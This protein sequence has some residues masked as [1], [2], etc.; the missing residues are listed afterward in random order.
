MG[1]YL[2]TIYSSIP[3]VR[4]DLIIRVNPKAISEGVR[5]TRIL[6]NTV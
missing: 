3:N 6:N 5:E 1:K 4:A 2:K